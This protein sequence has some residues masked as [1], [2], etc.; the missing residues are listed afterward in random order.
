M[1]APFPVVNIDS[2]VDD[3]LKLMTSKKNSAV[4]IEDQ[5]KIIG[6]LTRYDVIEFWRK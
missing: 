6:I 4:L 2:L 3:F 5:Q 1:D